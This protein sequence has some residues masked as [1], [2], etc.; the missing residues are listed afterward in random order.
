MPETRVDSLRGQTS[1]RGSRSSVILH[2]GLQTGQQDACD[3]AC[4]GQPAYR[5]RVSQKGNSKLRT[6][7]RLDPGDNHDMT[8]D[9]P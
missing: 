2:N 5:K 6:E 8:G 1:H 3:S 4:C 7:N 9:T